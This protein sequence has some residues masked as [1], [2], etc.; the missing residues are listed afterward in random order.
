M[1]KI[2]DV[3]DENMTM[4][5]RFGFKQ[6]SG[7]FVMDLKHVNKAYGNLT[8]LKDAEAQIERGIKLP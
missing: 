4:N 2:E 6:K 3:V 5:F 8:I 7:R 1:D